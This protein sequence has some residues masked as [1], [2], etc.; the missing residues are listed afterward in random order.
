MGPNPQGKGFLAEIN[1][2]PFVDVMLVLLIIFMVT[3]PMLEQGVKVDL[4]RTKTVQT[5]PEDSDHVVL[6]V[7]EDGSIYLDEY[8]VKLKEIS[9]HLKRIAEEKESLVYLRADA[10]VPYGRVVDLM[11]RVKEA[12]ITRLGVVAEEEG[13]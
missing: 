3:A 4:P 1:V 11:T 12:G 2:V 13:E 5:L 8:K 9:K 6:S 10:E 7:R